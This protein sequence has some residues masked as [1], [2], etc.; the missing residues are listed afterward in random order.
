VGFNRELARFEE[1][2]SG[3]KLEIISGSIIREKLSRNERM[4]EWFMSRVV[5]DMLLDEIA[6]GRPLFYT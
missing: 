4:P 1:V 2:R 5:Q 3:A 6:A